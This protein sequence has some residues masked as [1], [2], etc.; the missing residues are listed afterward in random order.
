L[1]LVLFF[2]EKT[3]MGSVLPGLDRVPGC[4]LVTGTV[5]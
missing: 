3:N 2:G 1:E 4:D 5:V